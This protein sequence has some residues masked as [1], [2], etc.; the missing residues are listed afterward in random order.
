MDEQSSNNC[1]HRFLTYKASNIPLML[2]GSL[3]AVLIDFR[4][5]L[6]VCV[7]VIIP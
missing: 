3:P 4:N 6:Y 2:S 7:E 1:I 5:V